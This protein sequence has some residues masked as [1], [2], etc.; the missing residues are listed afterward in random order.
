MPAQGGLNGFFEAFRLLCH[1][2]LGFFKG[3]ANGVIASGP[4]VVQG[5]LVAAQVYPDA[6]VCQALPEVDYV[7]DV[8]Q[9]YY[10]FGGTGLGDA[11][12]ELV[13]VVVEFVH[14]ALCMAFFC[15]Q[16]VDFCGYAYYAGYV[17]RFGLRP[18]HSAQSRCHEQ[19]TLFVILSAVEGSLCQHLP[20]RI[21]HCD[22]GAVN[23]ALRANIHITARCHLA[24]LRYAKGVELLP[25]VRLGVI[26]NN[27]SVGYHYARGVLV[28]RKKAHRVAGV[29]R[30]GLLI[31]HR[32]KILHGQAVL[33][34]VLE[35]GAVSA[36]DYQLVRVLGYARVQVVLDHGH[37]GCC[38][39][40]FCWVF[41]NRTG[42]HLIVRPVAVHVDS[43]VVFQFLGEFR[44]QLRVLAGREVAQGVL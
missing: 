33:G 34:P 40:G 5:G 16:G 41:V 44:G 28:G 1:H 37:N 39:S 18:G 12:Q 21:K 6:F 25:V 9:G 11:G 32:C 35:D 22:G 20:C 14:P 23:N 30:Q 26:G 31:G 43:A 29:H 27:H 36:V 10:F 17:A 38:L 2:L 7:A 4:G 3:V 15:G 19:H 42:V 24:V 13:K 8:C